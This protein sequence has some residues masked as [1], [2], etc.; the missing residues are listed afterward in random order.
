MRTLA[1]LTIL[2]PVAFGV[3]L[4]KRE[5]PTGNVPDVARLLSGSFNSTAQA[6]SDAGHPELRLAIVPIW[7]KRKDGPWFYVEQAASNSADQPDRQRVYR[8][9]IGE[10]GE[11]ISEIYK[12]P[13][14]PL[15]FTGEQKKKSPLA[16]VEPSQLEKLPGC[17]LH[18]KPIGPHRYQGGTVGTRCK[19]GRDNAAYT[20]SELLLTEEGLDSW[21]R[22]FDAA[23]KQVGGADEG[24]TKFRR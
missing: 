12:L 2:L 3:C 11:V 1:A 21:D 4:D 7:S 15:R 8:L 9:V 5:T 19:D 14:D 10:G 17:E 23:G 16:S 24:P 20:T 18:L 13:G 22:G 6:A